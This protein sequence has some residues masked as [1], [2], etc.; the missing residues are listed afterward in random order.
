M[1]NNTLVILACIALC[2][3]CGSKIKENKDKV[4][5][6]HLQK[7]MELIIISTPVPGDKS[8]FNL[9][10]LNDGQDMEKLRV[11]E[12]LDSLWKKK[13]INP[14][15]V[16]GVKATDRNE[17]YGVAGLPDYQ[18]KGKSAEKYENFI[19][20]ELLPY[21][22]KMS[23]VRKFSS[24]IFAGHSLGGLSAFDI[25]WDNWQKI[26]KVGVFSGPFGLSDLDRNDP[27]YSPDKNRLIIKK[28][29]SSRR[30]PK[31]KYWFYA[32]E[33]EDV[34]TSGKNQDSDVKEN[35]KDLIDLIKKKKVCPPG[36]IS[37]S[38]FPGGKNDVNSWS[39]VFPA[40]LMWAVGK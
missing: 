27:V 31:L 38:D 13:S 30:K 36:D 18:G 20:N 9:L 6:R 14:L 2:F 15:L 16:V 35:T 22:S 19:K 33:D 40:F 26:D 23:G 28:L 24:I 5:S 17:L 25:A 1:K 37:Y 39:R 8:D 21:A 3:G 29:T 10:I 12:I 7:H 34:S 11:K 32:G 4:Y